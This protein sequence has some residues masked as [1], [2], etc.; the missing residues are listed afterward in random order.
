MK[1]KYP[2]KNQVEIFITQCTDKH[3]WYKGL[4]NKPMKAIIFREKTRNAVCLSMLDHGHVLEIQ[5]EDFKIIKG[6][7]IR[8][9]LPKLV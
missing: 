2:E 1:H 8:K 6:R 7:D 3:D 5:D 9:K 4:I